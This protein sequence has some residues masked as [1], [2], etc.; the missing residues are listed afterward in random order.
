M[1]DDD[2]PLRDV[3]LLPDARHPPPGH[4]RSTLKRHNAVF[5]AVM[6]LLLVGGLT[7]RRGLPQAGGSPRRKRQDAFAE[8]PSAVAE[9]APGVAVSSSEGGIP[10]L[11]PRPIFPPRPRDSR[12][13]TYPGPAWAPAPRPRPCP[14][15]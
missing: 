2:D 13:V 8:P 14:P 1:P 11:T 12:P 3:G 7:D 10:F 5:Q 4:V 6:R 9:Q 15:G